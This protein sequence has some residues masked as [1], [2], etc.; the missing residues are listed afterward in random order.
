MIRRAVILL[1]RFLAP[2]RGNWFHRAAVLVICLFTGLGPKGRAQTTASGDPCDG[3]YAYIIV[4]D[5]T[6]QIVA[7]GMTTSKGTLNQGV[8]LG[9]NKNYTMTVARGDTGKIGSG[10][11]RTGDNGSTTTIPKIQV[12]E[13][14]S[15]DSDGDGVPDDIER[16]YGTNPRN[17][18]TLGGGISDKALINTPRLPG[19]GG[20]LI[21]NNP[22]FGPPGMISTVQLPGKSVDVSTFNNLAA[23]ACLDQGIVVFN[24]FNGLAP[25]QVAVV[26]TPGEARAVA[27][28]DLDLAV[29][30]GSAGL[31]I[32]DLRDLAS[33]RIRAQVH[34]GSYAEAVV[35]VGGIACVGLRSGQLVVVDL[36]SGAEIQRLSLGGEVF[37]VGAGGDF[38]FAIAGNTL[39]AFS[40]TDG[41]LIQAGSVALSSIGPDPLSGRKRLF[42]G[43]GFVLASCSS[44]FDY[45]DVTTPGAMKMLGKAVTGPGSFKQIIADGS[46]LG[47]AAVGINPRADGTHD[48]YLYNLLNPA[49]T[50]DLLSVLP[51]PGT[52]YANSIFNGLLYVADGEKGFEAYR[53]KETDT[54]GVP[55]VVTLATSASA[56]K[57][58][59][60]S[61]AGVSGG[62]AE[63]GKLFRVT[64]LATDDHQV[65]NVEFYLDGQLMETDGNFP[66][67]VLFNTP[68]STAAKN[69]FTVR[70]RAFD[71]GGNF[72]WSAPVTIGLGP[73]VTPPLVARTFPQP[74]TILGSLSA[75][76]AFFSE[77]LQ[78]GTVVPDAFRLMNA[79]PDGVIGT[80]D[81]FP[82]AG[83]VLTYQDSGHA[84][85]WTFP[86][87]LAPGVW[88]GVIS[89]P[90]ADRSGNVLAQPYKFNFILFNQ[91]DRD[92]DGVPDALEPLLGLDPDNPD[93]KGDG[94]RDGDRDYDND[95]LSNAAEVLLGTDPRK[96][97]TNGNGIRDGDEDADNDGLPNSKEALYGTNPLVADTDGDGWSDEAEVTA[98]SDPLDP[99][100]TP[101]LFF[102][103]QPAAR[104]VVPEFANRA[105]SGVTLFFVGQPKVSLNVNGRTGT[106]V[107]LGTVI[108]QPPVHLGVASFV[109]TDVGLG[110]VLALP[111]VHIGVTGSSA[112]ASLNTLFAEPPVKIKFNSQ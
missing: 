9:A 83:G 13:S 1:R 105:A 32:V 66:F 5:E 12:G 97:D 98:G 84:A 95:G 3:E 111:P 108:A 106:D 45:V 78:P 11:F 19:P 40:F 56:Q 77:P 34:L 22:A 112:D 43:A 71:M 38:I 75:V 88:H 53:Y 86:A 61:A 8:A 81:D 58:G 16:V 92:H 110:T 49:V 44:S 74:N 6:G 91:P 63:E 87:P 48:I 72:A 36:A 2:A 64:A 25:R 21:Q 47:T 80:A 62:V 55:P 89:A 23:V 35:K 52:A 27:I 100:S 85:V 26:D 39:R 96:A 17:P 31:A 54:K 29:A 33:A 76:I 109:G 14:I 70:A 10:H 50:S 94:I 107:A 37:D 15:R 42:V 82:A 104:F 93:S 46:G 67:E 57:G 65:R 79:G 51:T 20:I 7:Q 41:V 28:P 60:L 103:A 99:A 102:V 69:S 4:D 68:L 59:S 18:S 30:D 101:K 24:I 90:I 73:D